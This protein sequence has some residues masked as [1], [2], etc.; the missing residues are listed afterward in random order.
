MQFCKVD[1]EVG[2]FEK[3]LDLLTVGVLNLYVGWEDTENHLQ[4]K[5]M[6]M[7]IW[8]EISENNRPWVTPLHLWNIEM[9]R[10]S[11]HWDEKNPH[12]PVIKMLPPFCD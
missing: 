4:E 6:A 3:V 5:T 10:S 12:Y 1:P 9:K 8:W 2:H 11:P 7:R